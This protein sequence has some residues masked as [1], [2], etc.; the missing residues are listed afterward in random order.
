MISHT[1]FAT[2]TWVRHYFTQELEFLSQPE[3]GILF[4]VNA[5]IDS[6]YT[7]YLFAMSP[8]GFYLLLGNDENDF[9]VIIPE[10][11]VIR[12]FY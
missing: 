10:E 3:R 2:E 11:Y 12:S 5:N 7:Y 9:V 6:N 4:T 8:G 1:N